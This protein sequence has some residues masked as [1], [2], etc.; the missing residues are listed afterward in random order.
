MQH[1]SAPIS[2]SNNNNFDNHFVLLL[3]DESGSFYNI[4]YYQINTNSGGSTRCTAAI[5][6]KQAISHHWRCC[7]ATRPPARQPVT[8]QETIMFTKHRLTV[9]IG[10]T[11]HKRLIFFFIFLFSDLVD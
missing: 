1:T 10:A 6:C 9:F 4:D 11:K 8:T 5:I 7:T 2:I 3:M